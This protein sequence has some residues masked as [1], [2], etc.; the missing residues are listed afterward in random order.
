MGLI[1]T[2]IKAKYNGERDLSKSCLWEQEHLP[3]CKKNDKY[4]C[5]PCWEEAQKK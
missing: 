4:K 5:R 3:K 2:Y 1:P